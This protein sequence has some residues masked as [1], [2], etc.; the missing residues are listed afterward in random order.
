M[1]II[2][3]IDKKFEEILLVTA[4]IVMICLIFLQVLSRYIINISLPWTEE[5]SR[6]LF[7]WTVWMAVPYAVIKGRHIRLTVIRDILNDTGKFIMDL[8]FFILSILF[9]G[10]IGYM[11]IEL[12]GEIM[13]MG[14]LTPAVGIPKWVCY[15]SLPVGTLLAVLRFLEWGIRRTL[16]FIKDP[17]DNETFVIEDEELE[18]Q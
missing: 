15:L 6:Y 9:F 14:Q 7:I 3:I 10:Y 2:K 12:V 11:G 5:I 4:T 18:V 8:I 16:R 13:N 17:T 1:K